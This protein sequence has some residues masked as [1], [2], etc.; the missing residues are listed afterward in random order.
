MHNMYIVHIVTS[1][2][3]FR[4]MYNCICKS[5]YT[6]HPIT[7]PVFWKASAE[8]PARRSRASR[9]WWLWHQTAPQSLSWKSHSTKIFNI[10]KPEV[11]LW[12]VWVVGTEE[13]IAFHVNMTLWNTVCGIK[14]KKY[15]WNAS[16]LNIIER[17]GD[18]MQSPSRVSGDIVLKF[19][20][21]MPPEEASCLRGFFFKKSCLMG[22][23]GYVCP[24]LLPDLRTLQ[25]QGKKNC[26]AFHC[27]LTWT[28]G[29]EAKSGHEEEETINPFITQMEK[30]HGGK[31]PKSTLSEICLLWNFQN[32]SCNNCL[33]R[34]WY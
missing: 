30:P 4:N 16:K 25:F 31:C 32:N 28:D 10:A 21:Q 13:N 33:D 11:T 29:A 6:G 5:Q 34:I 14:K 3:T 20:V 18:C 26:K 22:V 8:A 17:E 7:H 15:S 23:V 19:S 12:P 27:R 1:H 2:D 24:S 9:H